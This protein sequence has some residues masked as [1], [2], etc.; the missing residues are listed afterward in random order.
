MHANQDFYLDP[1][2]RRA[3]A[4][5]VKEALGGLS[6]KQADQPKLVLRI[7]DV[8][9]HIGLSESTI[10]NFL[11]TDGPWFDPSFPQPIRLGAGTGTR[12]SIGWR[13]VDIEAWVDSRP[14]HRVSHQLAMTGRKAKPGRGRGQYT[15]QG[16]VLR[17]GQ[18][19]STSGEV[20]NSDAPYQSEG[21]TWRL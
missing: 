7:R 10:R 5:A 4:Q 8:A 6:L 20:C 19:G 11:D 18:V 14:A 12:S 16:P 2:L 9:K 15:P 17:G 13:R 21:G 3:I 1:A